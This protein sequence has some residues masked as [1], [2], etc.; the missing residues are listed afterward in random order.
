M[1][2][3]SQCIA[4]WVDGNMAPSGAVLDASVC[5]HAPPGEKPT[6][7]GGACRGGHVGLALKGGRAFPGE[8]PNTL[9]H[10]WP[11]QAGMASRKA[12]LEET[13]G[14]VARDRQ[15]NKAVSA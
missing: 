3:F 14:A 7:R 2:L 13:R 15:A 6:Y 8:D 10:C 5:K 9:S 12:F 4:R 1:S 11:A